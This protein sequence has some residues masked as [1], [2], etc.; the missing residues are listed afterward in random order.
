MDRLES[1]LVSFFKNIY[2]FITKIRVDTDTYGDETEY[3]LTLF[4]DGKKIQN[5]LP[6][7]KNFIDGTGKLKK[8]LLD[9]PFN[10]FTMITTNNTSDVN[11]SKS[12]ES[13]LKRDFYLARRMS[14]TQFKSGPVTLR[15][16]LQ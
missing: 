2:P 3:T 12:L 11:K 7:S 4:C 9:R 6:L 14:G 10:D 13:S 5:Y 1:I 16:V 15:I 8:D